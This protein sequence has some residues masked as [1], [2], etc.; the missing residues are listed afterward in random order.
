MF[1][2]QILGPSGYL[3]YALFAVPGTWI[4]VLCPFD[5]VLWPVFLSS[6]WHGL[7]V[8]IFLRVVPSLGIWCRGM[9]IFLCPIYVEQDLAIA[10]SPHDAIKQVLSGILRRFRF[11]SLPSSYLITPYFG[12]FVVSCWSLRT[13]SRDN[14]QAAS[15]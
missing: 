15:E 2:L 10:G 13:G 7:V 9:S 6:C 11:T 12:W 5:F 8:R 14:R 3:V 4:S 1:H